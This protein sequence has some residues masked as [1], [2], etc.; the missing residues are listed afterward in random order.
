MSDGDQKFPKPQQDPVLRRYLASVRDWHGYIRF[1]GLPHL[2]ENPDLVIDRLFVEP[3]LAASHIAPESPP[4]SWPPTTDLLETLSARPRL[5]L[6]GDPGSGK[7]TLVS[8]LAWQFAQPRETPWTERLGPLVPL[9][10]VLRELA[11]GPD[12]T[13]EGLMDA[14]LGHAMS[15]PLSERTALEGVLARGQGFLMLD[16]LDELGELETRTALRRAVREGMK[17]YPKCRWL[18]TSRIV[19]YEDV[20]F[21][22]AQGDVLWRR[23]TSTPVIDVGLERGLDAVIT[24]FPGSD[25]WGLEMEGV[26]IVGPPARGYVAPF[27]D[28]QI[29]RFAHCWYQVREPVKARAAEGAQDLLA[30]VRGDPTTQRLA[31]IPNLLTMMAL[32][33]RVRA[34]LPH[35][36]ALL[37]GEIAQAYLQSIDEFRG[38]ARTDYSL[39]QKRRWLARVGFEMQHRRAEGGD[40]TESQAGKAILADATQVRDW[41]MA[42]MVDS[43]LGSDPD[44]ADEFIRYI[45]RRSGLLLPRGP[46][47]FA[48]LHLSF[49]EYFAALFL[50]EQV[51]SPR[52][53]REG[54][55]APGATRDDLRAYARQSAW[56]ETLL[57]LF[58]LLADQPGWPENLAAD[59]FGAD[60]AE[61]ATPNLAAQPA[62]V[63][64]ARISVDPHSGLPT[65][66]RRRGIERCMERELRNQQRFFESSQWL[67]YQPEI[68]RWLFGVQADQTL[69]WEYLIKIAAEI[70]LERLSFSG[71]DQ[72]D[73][74]SALESLCGLKG[75]DLY[76][77]GTRDLSPLRRLSR[78]ESLDLSGEPEQSLIPISRLN[79][80]ERL[81]CP[82]NA[83][84]LDGLSKLPSLS[85][86][87]I[88]ITENQGLDFLRGLVALERL[89]LAFG[90]GKVDLSPLITL[91]NLLRLQFY[92]L[93]TDDLTPL[94]PCERLEYLGLTST[95][96]AA[97]QIEAF[98][99]A[100]PEVKVEVADLPP[101]R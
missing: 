71:C 38:I 96:L 63:L 33:H 79:F 48:F 26:G 36:R 95:K 14:F 72:I 82:G 64:L 39:A 54:T 4:D 42:A 85:D 88:V 76:G 61:I 86:L 53:I 70:G 2:R 5:V 47:V 92:F 91:K 57:F 51:M 55:A 90:D 44:A 9:P 28:V 46:G 77:T 3:R 80:L 50:M 21:D 100:R 101:T 8:W 75:L 49:Q 32:I 87:F 27:T 73:D 59:L 93:D 20:P 24:A 16:G 37:Y 52:W 10:L 60:L 17:L 35:G 40:E 81:S 13:W 31:R 62:A 83:T 15:E 56:Q 97:G 23:L 1:L 99:H 65:L 11:L 41:V 78:L 18:L 43:G 58:E 34:R 94:Y 74:I 84:G 6:L 68:A 67:D 22:E 19:G 7:S 45:G 29:E 98:R 66:L 30:A 69:A 25:S 89:S 12:L